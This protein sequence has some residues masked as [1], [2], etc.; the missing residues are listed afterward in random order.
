MTMKKVAEYIFASVI[1][2]SYV[3]TLQ[4]QRTRTI[5]KDV[6]KV[7]LP[8]E[9]ENNWCLIVSEIVCPSDTQCRQ[10]MSWCHETDENKTPKS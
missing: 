5:P 2:I 1:Y 4:N 9:N 8:K 7:N 3:I 6:S 10:L